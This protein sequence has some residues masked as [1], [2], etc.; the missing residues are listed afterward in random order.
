MIDASFQQPDILIIQVW[1]YIDAYKTS[2]TAEIPFPN[3]VGTVVLKLDWAAGTHGKGFSI[4]RKRSMSSLASP[5]PAFASG[6]DRDG[7]NGVDKDNASVTGS[8][9]RFS[10]LRMSMARRHAAD[11]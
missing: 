3:G 11:E 7:A 4:G 9:G 5:S 8:P 10:A 6:K 2:D 1:Q